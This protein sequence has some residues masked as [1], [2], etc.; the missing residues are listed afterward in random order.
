[1][2]IEV[3]ARESRGK[4]DKKGYAQGVDKEKEKEGNGRSLK[5]NNT[6][7]WAGFII[8]RNGGAV[9][10]ILLFGLN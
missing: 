3:I 7:F 1:L 8:Q 10:M 9:I 2:A 6:K 5:S 4:K